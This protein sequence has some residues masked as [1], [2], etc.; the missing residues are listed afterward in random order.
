MSRYIKNLPNF[1]EKGLSIVAV[2]A[3]S[4]QFVMSAWKRQTERRVMILQVYEASL[5]LGRHGS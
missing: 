5:L 4:D 2:I 1:Y 3:F